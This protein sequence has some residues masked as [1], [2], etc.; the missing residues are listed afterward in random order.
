MNGHDK[1][2]KARIELLSNHPFFGTM[3]LRARFKAV[4]GLGTIGVA[5]GGRT[6]YFDPNFVE[7]IS[8]EETEGV[9]AHEVLHLAFDVFGRRGE[10]HIGLWNMAHD[11]AINLILKDSGLK[12]PSHI[13]IDG[14]PQPICMDEKYRGMAAE[15]IYEKLKKEAKKQADG[16]GDGSGQGG[17]CEKCGKQQGA[18]QQGGSDDDDS[19]DGDSGDGKPGD[20]KGRCECDPTNGHG[21]GRGPGCVDHSHYARGKNQGQKHQIQQEWRESLGAAVQAAKEQGKLPAGLDRFIDD[22]INPSLPW[23]QILRQFVGEHGCKDDFS[24][25]RPNRHALVR[26][27]YLPGLIST[28]PRI[29]IGIDTSGSISPDI[30]LMFASEINGILQEINATARVIIA[31]ADVHANMDTDSIEE[32]LENTKGGGGTDFRTAFEAFAEDDE[33]L[34]CIVFFTD[35]YATLPEPQ[36]VEV[37]VLWITPFEE[38]GDAPFGDV[39]VAEMD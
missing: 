8:G 13:M 27:L 15:E 39:F 33:G 11:Y 5:D 19:D 12:L 35:L 29:G 16:Q 4:D 3:A 2:K 9:V 7:S 21:I 32:I 25:R 22:L 10:R 23:D 31:D 34:D 36:Q 18:S 37:P 14:K 26:D 20:K 30:L 38:H 28:Q 1:L 6:I 24:W 17:K